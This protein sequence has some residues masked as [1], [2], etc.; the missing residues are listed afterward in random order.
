MRKAT[1]TI[2]PITPP[3]IASSTLKWL[4]PLEPLLESL[5][6]LLVGEGSTVK[7]GVTEELVEGDVAE[8][9]AEGE[10]GPAEAVVSVAA[11]AV[12]ASVAGVRE[13]AEVEGGTENAVESGASLSESRNASF[14]SKLSVE[15]TSR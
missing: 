1:T 15:I 7:L 8:E 3:M 4:E 9:S 5:L 11:G 2:A 12:L 14:T 10:G 13:L 6:L